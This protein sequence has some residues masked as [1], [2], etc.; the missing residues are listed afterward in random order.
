MPDYYAA[1]MMFDGQDETILSDYNSTHS[2]FAIE[3]GYVLFT[4]KGNL[5]QDQLWLREP[6]N[7]INQATFFATDSELE[8]LHDDGTFTFFN[9]KYRY[10]HYKTGNVKAISS[11][12][13]KAFFKNDKLYLTIGGTLLEVDTLGGAFSIKDVGRSM[14]EGSVLN[15]SRSDFDNVVE[16]NGPLLEISIIRP[17]KHGRLTYEGGVAG[18]IPRFGLHLLQY[19]ADNNYVGADTA[20]WKASNGLSTTNE[21]RII[22]TIEAVT[23]ILEAPSQDVG[24]YP[25]PVN[26]VLTVHLK[27]MKTRQAR[28]IVTNLQGQIVHDEA[29]VVSEQT[30]TIATKPLKPGIFVITIIHEHGLESGKFVKL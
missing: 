1:L 13:G 3:N 30:I 29:Q 9:D 28:V 11:S 12:Q 23:A 4:R 2:K 20:F 6:S 5:N 21:A 16:G 26:D 22:I 10:V 8:T 15:F 24:L 7:E 18:K 25:N 19:E 17:P 27:G 14:P